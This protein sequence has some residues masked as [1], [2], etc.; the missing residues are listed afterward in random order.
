M[1][2]IK[3]AKSVVQSGFV[4]KDTHTQEG[5]AVSNGTQISL[6]CWPD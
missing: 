5:A 2:H 3:R 4:A 6:S 1:A